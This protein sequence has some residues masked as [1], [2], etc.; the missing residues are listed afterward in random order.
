MAFFAGLRQRYARWLD[1]R[2]PQKNAIQLHQGNL[3]IF[4]SRQGLYF[5][6]LFALIWIGATNYQNNLAYALGFFMLSILLVAILLTFSNLSGLRL[7]YVDVPAVFS[8]EVAQCRFEVH[9]ATEHQQ[10]QFFWPQQDI[11]TINVSGNSPMYFSVA[12]QATKR[13]LMRPGRLCVKSIY[14]LGVV[15]CW[16]WLDWGAEV[17]VYPAPVEA[18]YRLCSVSSVDNDGV[19]MRGSDEYYSLKPYNEGESLSRIAWKQYAAGRGLF[20]R[21]H[22]SQQGTDIWLDFSVMVDIDAEKRLSKLC[23]CAIQLHAAGRVFGLRLPVLSIEPSSGDMH[24]RAV[25]RAL[26]LYPV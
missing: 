1:K 19:F 6:L 23:Y 20:V 22:V 2:I 8:G 10:L 15:R 17:L 4:L 3:F 26:A 5:L 24:F 16:T 14:P 18:D 13:G 25:L 12:I 7:R 21:E 9:S 11:A